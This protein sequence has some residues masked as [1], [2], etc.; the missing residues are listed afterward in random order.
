MVDL[1]HS[2]GLGK[3]DARSVVEIMSK[4]EPFF[5]NLMMLEELEMQVRKKAGS[6]YNPSLHV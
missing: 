3:D 6:V 5:V 4:N 2:K 1:Y